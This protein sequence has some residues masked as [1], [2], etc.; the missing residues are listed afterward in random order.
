MTAIF[1]SPYA[2]C[3]GSAIKEAD[4]LECR[5][6]EEQNYETLTREA[7]RGSDEVYRLRHVS[8]YTNIHWSINNENTTTIRAQRDKAHN[9]GLSGWRSG[10]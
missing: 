5:V 2:A 3:I 6:S 1:H 7:M 8:F 9:V 10:H 4:V